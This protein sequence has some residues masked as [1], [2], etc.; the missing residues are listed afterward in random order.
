[1]RFPF[2]HTEEQIRKLFQEKP[3]SSLDLAIALDIGQTSARRI[4][5]LYRENL[6]VV[7]HDLVGEKGMSYE[8]FGVRASPDQKDLPRPSSTSKTGKDRDR[9]AH[10][11]KMARLKKERDENLAMAT[12]EQERSAIL[13]TYRRG[14]MELARAAASRKLKMNSYWREYRREKRQRGKSASASQ[15]LTNAL[16][17]RAA[18]DKQDKVAA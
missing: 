15:L 5:R 6:V 9:K 16:F 2:N 13:E 7:G 12:T 11:N 8:V 3:R 10:E 4:I 14:T 17:G 1:M 18:N